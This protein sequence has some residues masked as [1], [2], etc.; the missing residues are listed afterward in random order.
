MLLLVLA[1]ADIVPAVVSVNVVLKVRFKLFVMHVKMILP[2]LGV[3]LGM[4]STCIE[5]A[6]ATFFTWMAPHSAEA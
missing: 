2:M 3:C 5:F 6:H 1:D 4:Q